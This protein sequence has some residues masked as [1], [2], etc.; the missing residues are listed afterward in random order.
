MT[1][2]I[3]YKPQERGFAM[4]NSKQIQ[5]PD[6]LFNELIAYF[7]LEPGC[8]DELRSLITK[9]LQD[10]LDKMA[11]R[12]LY[13]KYKDSRLSPA[14]KE[15]ARRDYLEMRGIHPDFIWPAG[16]EPYKSD[17]GECKLPQTGDEELPY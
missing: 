11:A 8:M 5:I 6:E 16:Y 3:Y 7:L 12:E 10:K 15:Q 14:E 4:K 2:F 9:G 13:S 1:I 17:I